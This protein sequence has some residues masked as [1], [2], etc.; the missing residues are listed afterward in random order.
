MTSQTNRYFAA[1]AFALAAFSLCATSSAADTHPKAEKVVKAKKAKGKKVAAAEEEHALASS[2]PEPEIADTITVDYACEL[3]NKVT[4]Y[5]MENDSSQMALRWKKR[6]HRMTRVGTSTGASR[7]ENTSA[8]L[9]WIGIPAKSML[10]DSKANRQLANE[11]RNADQ[12]K[13]VMTST[14][15]GGK[16]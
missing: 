13:S 14:P 3:G 7:F 5:T 9:V 4:I 11:C 10:L 15:V 1:C 12:N 16:S 6:L 2:E 8:G